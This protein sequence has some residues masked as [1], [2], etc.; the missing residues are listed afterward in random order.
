MQYNTSSNYT[1][2]TYLVRL[3]AALKDRADLV[4]AIDAACQELPAVAKSKGVQSFLR[5]LT[6]NPT[7]ES[8]LADP[9]LASW[10]PV[11]ISERTEISGDQDSRLVRLAEHLYVEEDRTRANWFASLYPLIVLALLLFV[12][13]LLS[14]SVVP[15][16]SK[17]FNEFQLKLPA[18]TLLVF[19]ISRFITQMPLMF[20]F[21]LFLLVGLI[22]GL[23]KWTHRLVEWCELDRSVGWL[24][25]G[26]SRNLASMSRFIDS[27]R[28]ALELEAPLADAF[29]I[30]GVASNRRQF[31][32]RAAQLANEIRY[33]DGKPFQSHVAHVFPPI[34]LHAVHAGEGGSPSFSLL[35]QLAENYRSRSKQESAWVANGFGPIAIIGIGLLV[36]FTIIALFMP[37]ITLVT[38]LSGS[39]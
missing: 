32:V 36:G 24:T 15:V 35:R 27:L 19:S 11:L 3:D 13:V 25:A 5:A 16:F 12:L 28:T 10:L 6:Q 22:V 21:V 39:S 17:M 2:P 1:R 37:L 7:S 31:R 4:S 20:C 9:S 29:E 34:L 26:S 38:A 14:V 8:F 23:T 18:P 30:A 33:S